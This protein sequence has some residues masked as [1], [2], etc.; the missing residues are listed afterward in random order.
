MRIAGAP[1]E[2]VHQS[3]AQLARTFLAKRRLAGEARRLACE[4]RRLAVQAAGKVRLT[5]D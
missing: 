3:W 2:L 5:Y 4:A 1:G